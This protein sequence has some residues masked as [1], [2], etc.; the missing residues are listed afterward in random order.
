MSK[1][2]T[3]SAYGRILLA[4]P[5]DGETGEISLRLLRCPIQRRE[6]H[7]SS[8]GLIKEYSSGKGNQSGRV[9]RPQGA[10]A[11]SGMGT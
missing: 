7:P 1:D 5:L 6:L 3:H 11:C 4:Y 9:G 8:W 10:P 2:S